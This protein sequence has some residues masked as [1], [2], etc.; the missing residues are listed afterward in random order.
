VSVPEDGGSLPD[1]LTAL[2]TAC[3][4]AFDNAWTGLQERISAGVIGAL[5]RGREA[6]HGIVAT[7]GLEDDAPTEW[8]ERAERLLEYRRS[9]ADEVLEPIRDSF[10]GGG[11]LS[12]LVEAMGRALDATTEACRALPE[13]ATLPWRDGALAPRAGDRRR[14]RLGKFFARGVSAVRKTGRERTVALRAVALR[15]LHRTVSPGMDL[16]AEASLVRWAEWTRSLEMAWVTWGDAALPALVRAEL[17]GADDA[18]EQWSTVR[19]AARA[20][21]ARMD[22][23]IA[24]TPTGPVLGDA[25][26]VLSESRERLDA[27]VAVA[28]SFLY[29]PKE[30]NGSAPSLP[31]IARIAPAGRTWDDCV[32]ARLTLYVSLL[33]ILSGTTALQRR[34]VWRMRERVLAGTKVLPGIAAELEGLGA[35]FV[36]SAA[37]MRAR[38]DRI[39]TRIQEVLRPTEDAVPLAADLGATVLKGADSTVDALLAMIRQAPT[40]LVLHTEEARLPTGIRKVETR[41]IPLQELARQSFDA[42]RIERMRASTEGLVGAVE[43]ARRDVAELPEVFSF[44]Y[45]AAQGEL[46]EGGDDA[47]DR[48][49]GLVTE[50]L[51][52]MAESLRNVSKTLS[53]AI[54]DVQTRLATE[55]VD[56]SSRLVD[57]IAAGRMQA[58]LLAARSRAAA[59]RA[60]INERWGPPTDRA[61]RALAYRWSRLRRLV[62]RGVRKGSEIVAGT[63]PGAAASARGVKALTDASATVSR[64]PLVYQRLFTLEPLADASLLANRSAELADGMARWNRWKSGDGVP[65]LLWGR[66]GCGITSFLNVLETRMEEGGGQVRRLDIPDRIGTEAELASLLAE[67]LDLEPV[68]TLDALASSIFDAPK[69]TTPDAVAIDNLEHLY[70]RVPK[71]TDLIERL[72]TLM[73]ETEPRIFWMGAIT[74]SA[75]QLVRAAEPTAISQVDA[76]ELPPL[77]AASVRA[78]ITLRHRRS[79]LPVRFEEPSSGRRLLRRRLR[80]LRDP[81][82]HAELLEADFFDQLHR[83]SAGHL[84]LALLQWLMSADFTQGDGVFMHPPE[85]PD[86]GVL[87]SLGLIQNFTLKALLEHRSLS[88]EEHDRI[89]RLPRHESYQIFESLGNRHLIET[90]AN[91][92]GNGQARSEIEEN[93]RYRVRPLLAGAIMTHL[94]GRNIVH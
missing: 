82:A 73:A 35:D 49:A 3:H 1:P 26:R 88:L 90:L 2:D 38:L 8:E 76:V 86:L 71:G 77:D 93:L 65:F 9:L 32:G 59:L 70:L 36:R 16:V 37:P 55:I 58:R 24:A 20:L 39:H 41:A 22:E 63:S 79:G 28:G 67:L 54:A 40:S 7:V 81:A 12:A 75:W 91:S 66:P 92:D 45:E 62:S 78:A 84:R 89:F 64:L 23:L 25:H 74:G 43:Q 4:A 56:G 72:L 18:D 60:W 5:E 31:R 51:N 69:A 11:P 47:N 6:H 87:E 21:D 53:G 48:A 68:E 10:D 17:P 52:G 57:R 80:R 46:E 27:D 34:L 44:A 42:L 14:R 15:H 83:T 30:P 19:S 94:R 33:S 13:E 50:A 61:A 29:R 85:R